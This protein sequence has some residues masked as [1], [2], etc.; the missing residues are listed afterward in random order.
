MKGILLVLSLLVVSVFCGYSLILGN[1]YA[2]PWRECYTIECNAQITSI[3][4][5]SSSNYGSVYYTIVFSAVDDVQVFTFNST[6]NGGVINSGDEF[7]GA[8]FFEYSYHRNEVGNHVLSIDNGVDCGDT[9]GVIF[10]FTEMSGS[11]GISIPP[12]LTYQ[13]TYSFRDEVEKEETEEIEEIEEIEEKVEIEKEKSIV[14]T[15]E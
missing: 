7:L 10:Q 4:S 11:C 14:N 12:E 9:A 8:T 13:N 5:N 15:E 6:F 2:T 3:S 1:T